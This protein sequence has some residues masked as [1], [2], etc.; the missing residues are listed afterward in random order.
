MEPTVLTFMKT[1]HKIMRTALS[2]HFNK[3]REMSILFQD[4]L[5]LDFDDVMYEKRNKGKYRY[6]SLRDSS[7]FQKHQAL[8]ITVISLPFKF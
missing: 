7:L 1:Q 3:P 6:E 2:L 4:L 8:V 5:C